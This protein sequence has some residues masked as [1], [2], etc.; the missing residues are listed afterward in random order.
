MIMRKMPNW[1]AL[2]LDNVR[3]HWL[4]NLI[5][6]HDKLV[7]YLQDCLNSGVPPDWLTRGRTVLIRLLGM[8]ASSPLISEN[9]ST[10]G[11][12]RDKSVCFQII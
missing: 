11:K 6:L 8:E 3:G 7:V 5:P 12:L 2:G 9:L 4:K 1:K 10:E